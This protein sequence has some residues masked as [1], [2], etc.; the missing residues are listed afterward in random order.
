MHALS[1]SAWACVAGNV[2]ARAMPTSG[3]EQLVILDH[4]LYHRLIDADR[5]AICELVR[6]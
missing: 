3:A 4:G 2:Y 5:L 6:A 1:G